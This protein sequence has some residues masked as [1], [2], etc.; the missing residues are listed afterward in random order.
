MMKNLFLA[1]L[2][3]LGFNSFSQGECS[4]ISN[5]DSRLNCYDKHFKKS[6][7]SIASKGKGKWL[8]SVTTNPVNDSRTVTL[9]LTADSGKSIY[10]K[11]ASL[12]IR[13]QS[14]K[15]EMFVSFHAFLGMDSAQ[16][17]SRVDK[18]KAMVENWG[19]STDKK[20]AFY[21]GSP[22]PEIKRMLNGKA[23]VAQVTPYSATPITAIFD[24]KGIDVAIKE[25]RK[26]CSW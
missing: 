19:L 3:M 9:Y 5:R 6:P 24:I 25:L 1:L 23:Y 18:R 26:T 12:I 22:I 8:S 13:C 11:K 4:T 17:T 16:V 15:T 7:R 21:P 2:F 14:N 20:A 10:G